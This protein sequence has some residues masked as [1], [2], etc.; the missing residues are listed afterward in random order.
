M[1]QHSRR[2]I[3]IP[4]FSKTQ[5]PQHPALRS[6]WGQFQHAFGCAAYQI[7]GFAAWQSNPLSSKT[8]TEGGTQ[9]AQATPYGAGRSSVVQIVFVE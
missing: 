4:D 8:N 6:A 9:K 7:Q 2:F 5:P 1:I 3:P